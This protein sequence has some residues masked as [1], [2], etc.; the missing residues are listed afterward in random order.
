M[1]SS[2]FLKSLAAEL[3]KQVVEEVFYGD[4]L[5]W[6]KDVEDSAVAET[7]LDTCQTKWLEKIAEEGRPAVSGVVH[8]MD[9]KDSTLQHLFR[10]CCKT[11]ALREQQVD[12]CS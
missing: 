12:S 2:R 8:D 11:Y 5:G 4:D 3:H 10:L 1:S 7:L 6:L 9:L